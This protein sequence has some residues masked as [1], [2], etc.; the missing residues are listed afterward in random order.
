MHFLEYSAILV[1]GLMRR[2]GRVRTTRDS[3]R[4]WGLRCSLGPRYY[5]LRMPL[6][7]FEASSQDCLGLLQSE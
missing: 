7:E 1:L 5:E 4:C 3:D 2:K 6:E